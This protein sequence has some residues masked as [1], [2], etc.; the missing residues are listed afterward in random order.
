[1]NTNQIHAFLLC[2]E[3]KSFSKAA[4]RLFITPSALYQQISKLEAELGFSLFSRNHYG[5]SLTQAGQEYFFAAQKA[6][7]LLAEAQKNAEALSRGA[8]ILRIS[9]ETSEYA[10]GLKAF[11]LAYPDVLIRHVETPYDDIQ[12]VY[13]LLCNHQLDVHEGEYTHDIETRG[14]V[15]HPFT[16]TYLC[17]MTSFRNPL[18]AKPFVKLSELSNKSTHFYKCL[19]SAAELLNSQ[20]LQSFTILNTRYSSIEVMNSIEDGNV[21]IMEE[22]YARRLCPFGCPIRIVPEIPISY[23]FITRPNHDLAARF[24]DYL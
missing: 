8:Q 10:S 11:E 16:Q 12:F 13:D 21:Y 2:A 5:I 23:G 22:S 4:A 9:M 6:D 1:M 7:I 19:F 15:F 17:A 24:L 3:E 18:S 14:L 20:L